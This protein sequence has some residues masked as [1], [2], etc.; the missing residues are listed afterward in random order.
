MAMKMK[1]KA[2]IQQEVKNLKRDRIIDA[3][4][5][6]FYDKGFENTTLDAVADQ[7]GVR[8]PY[9]YSYFESKGDLLAQICETGVAEAVASVTKIMGEGGSPSD[10]LRAI[11]EITVKTVI[12]YQKHNVIWSREEMNLPPRYAARIKS[13]RR[14]YDEKLNALLIEGRACGEFDIA[15]TRLAT[16]AVSA[17]STSVQVWFKAAGR[18]DT[19]NAASGIADLVMTMV[20]AKPVV[21]T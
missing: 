5:E 15:D 9:I 12:K 3:A 2:S 20:G 8:K 17:I 10:Q 1:V 16:F 11:C 7:L 14:Q 6:L 21:K 4:V 19:K 18:L 13:I